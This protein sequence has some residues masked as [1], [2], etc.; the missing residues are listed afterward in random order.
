MEP[1]SLPPPPIPQQR[2]LLTP[3]DIPADPDGGLPWWKPT[4]VDVARRLG[5]RWLYM[6]PLALLLSVLVL[7]FF[8]RWSYFSLLFYG[9]KLWLWLGAGAMGAVVQAV[10]Q[11]TSARGE[12]FC[13][14]CGYTLE[15]L[16]DQ[17]ICPECGRPYSFGLIRQY[18]QDPGWFVKRW[19]LQHANPRTI[20]FEAGKVMGRASGDGT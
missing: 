1:E 8:A 7:A 19:K 3:S 6:I 2:L 14:H 15:G 12:P 10:R 4:W 18:Q 11:A 17:H 20:P 5:W 9:G 16:P 13:I